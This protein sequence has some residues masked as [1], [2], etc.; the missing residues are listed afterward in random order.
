MSKKIA[1]QFACSRLLLPEHRDRL[2]GHHR[3][4]EKEE[5]CRLPCLD[6]QQWAEFDFLIDQSF[7]QGIEIRVTA[8]NQEGRY[9]AAGRV[10]R[11]D[12]AKKEIILAGPEGLYKI[13]VPAITGMETSKN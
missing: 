7:K 13:F 5:E 1:N 4:K 10:V 3:A 6:E 9:S 8:I 12:L 11:L 2:Q